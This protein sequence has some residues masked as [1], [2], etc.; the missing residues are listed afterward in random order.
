MESLTGDWNVFR[1]HCCIYSPC[2]NTSGSR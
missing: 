1:K 2:F